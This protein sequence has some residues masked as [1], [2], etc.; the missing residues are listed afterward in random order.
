MA[1]ELRNALMGLGELRVAA[2][3]SS[4]YFQDKQLSPQAVGDSLNVSKN[5]SAAPA[6]PA[7]ADAT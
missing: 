1:E 5:V 7:T 4:V 3:A 6:F 2:R